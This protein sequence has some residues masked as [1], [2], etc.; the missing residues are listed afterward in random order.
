MVQRENDGDPNGFQDNCGLHID[1]ESDEAPVLQSRRVQLRRKMKAL[2]NLIP[3]C[4]T[5]DKATMLDDAIRYIKSL[6]DQVT[7]ASIGAGY[8]IQSP[9]MTSPAGYQFVHPIPQFPQFMQI[10]PEINKA[11]GINKFRQMNQLEVPL[12][13]FGPM[14]SSDSTLISVPL[15][16][17]LSKSPLMNQESASVM[18]L[19]GQVIMPASSSGTSVVTEAPDIIAEDNDSDSCVMRD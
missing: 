5:R 12:G 16:L 2:Q 7:T 9:N 19:P 18:V 14:F 13:C 8:M 3:N 1:L 4:N 17:E 15:S 6:Q 11:S 10:N